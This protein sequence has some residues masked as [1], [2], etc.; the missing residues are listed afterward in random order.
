MT[1]VDK[2][3][4]ATVRVH[5]PAKLNLTLRT[6]AR[7]QDGFHPLATLFQAVRTATSLSA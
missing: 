7:R 4:F 3:E 1:A 5:V 6:G 2:A